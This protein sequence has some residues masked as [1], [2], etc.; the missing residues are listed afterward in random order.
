L[1][2]LILL[3][4]GE[5]ARAAQLFNRALQVAPDLLEAHIGLGN[6]L[7]AQGKLREAEAALARAL[8]L[9]PKNIEALNTLGNC[10]QA[11][12]RFGEAEAVFRQAIA[13]NPT[14][15]ELHN[16][17]GNALQAVNKL[18]E[19]VAAFRE[20]IALK[21]DFP[22]AYSNL[23]NML[24]ARN[25]LPEAE[26]SYRRALE[27]NPRYVDAL[28]NLGNTLFAQGF[29]DEAIATYRRS[30]EMQPDQGDAY[31][32]ESLAQLGLGNLETGFFQYE[33]RW[34][35][36]LRHARR[37]F[38]QPLWLGEPELK[39]RTILLHAEQGLGDTLQFSRYAA[40]VAAGGATVFLEVQPALKSLLSG[41]PGVSAVFA[42]G[43]QL[44][45]F[46]FHCPLLSLPHACRTTLATIPPPG[47]P[48]T[49]S[50][51]R[52]TYWQRRLPSGSRPRVGLMWSGNPH[53]VS[54]RNRS[55]S[56]EDLRPL[57]AQGGV[58]FFSLQKDYRSEEERQRAMSLGVNDLSAEIADFDSTAALV[59]QLDLVISVDTSMTHLAGALDRPV[60]LLLMFCPDWRWLLHRTDSP[61]YPRTRLF[62]QE[63]PGDWAKPVE[64]IE[65]LLGGLVKD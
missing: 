7:A 65:A 10:L 3:G 30:Q 54:D 46:D 22:E 23:G 13:I 47:A 4:R 64:T 15:A 9:D 24:K 17:L 36:I 58:D 1:L 43:E 6:A 44:P 49:V 59:A 40:L 19:A 37:L 63:R 61:W 55:M 38:S 42:K 25:E 39:V 56:L 62:R 53:H 20:A 51:D 26:A 21:P 27:L 52:A 57:L 12:R 45:S 50:A 35:S 14:F 5:P 60:W 31:F 33:A 16:N 48:L 8:S 28:N 18:D 2:G 11:M 32:Y 29:G 34:K 41:L